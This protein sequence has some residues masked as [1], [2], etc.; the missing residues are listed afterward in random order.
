MNYQPHCI[1]TDYSEDGDRVFEDTQ[2]F[3]LFE[4]LLVYQAVC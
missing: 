1:W 2:S 3:G 4:A